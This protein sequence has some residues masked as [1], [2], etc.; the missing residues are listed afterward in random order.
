MKRS[1]VGALIGAALGFVS[2]LAL[3]LFVARLGFMSAVL[4]PG[5]IFITA[6]NGMGMFGHMVFDTLAY[7]S[8]VVLYAGVGYGIGWMIGRGETGSRGG[9]DDRQA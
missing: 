2:V 3:N 6:S 8:N 7:F 1:I 4:F 9:T 5:R